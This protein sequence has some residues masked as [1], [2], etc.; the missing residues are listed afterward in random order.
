M[1]NPPRKRFSL[2]QR[3]DGRPLVTDLATGEVLDWPDV[4]EYS[5]APGEPQVL[6]LGVVVDGLVTVQ[7]QPGAAQE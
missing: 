1:S 7:A 2:G 5:V 4:A 3:P 6:W